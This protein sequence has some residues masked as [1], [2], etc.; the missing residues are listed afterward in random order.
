[1]IIEKSM[2]L[3]ASILFFPEGKVVAAGGN[4]VS[5]AI[6]DPNDP[7][8]LDFQRVETWD[9]SRKGVKYEEAK[10][11]TTGRLQLA[12]E[13]ETDGHTEYKFTTNVVLAYLLGIFFRSGTSLT[14]ASTQFNPDAGVT[15]RGWLIISN[16]DQAGNLI[17][18]ANLWGRVKLDALKGGGGA[19]IKPEVM[20]TQYRNALNVMSV[21]T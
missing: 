17:I 13:V 4:C 5:T 2:A 21:G 10:D 19:L 15:P 12:D 6:P 14:A 20:F 18:S 3:G 16:R 1:M 9:F 7:G 11:G 8:W